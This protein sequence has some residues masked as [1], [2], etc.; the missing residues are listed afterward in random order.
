MIFPTI[1]IHFA[2]SKPYE[3]TLSLFLEYNGYFTEEIESIYADAVIE[4]VT[5]IFIP[6]NIYLPHVIREIID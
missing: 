3:K 4:S 1:V 2:A 6:K 5:D